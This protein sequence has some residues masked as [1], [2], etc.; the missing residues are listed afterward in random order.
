MK[1]SHYIPYQNISCVYSL[2]DSEWQNLTLVSASSPLIFPSL[3][4]KYWYVTMWLNYTAVLHNVSD[5]SHYLKIDVTPDSVRSREEGS[6]GKPLIYFS[7]IKQPLIDWT[8]VGVL[9][10]VIIVSVAL[11]YFKKVKP[12]HG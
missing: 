4:N 8:L 11:V 9:V 2:D 1:G 6:E 3:V 10:V 12:K 7:V 5:G